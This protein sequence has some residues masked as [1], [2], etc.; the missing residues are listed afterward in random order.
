[1]KTSRLL[2]PALSLA[3][4][5]GLGTAA[6]VA[7]DLDDVALEFTE[8][9]AKAKAKAK[10]LGGK[11]GK[12]DETHTLDIKFAAGALFNA[13]W[14]GDEVEPGVGKING[15]YERKNEFSKKL[16]LTVGADG[17]DELTTVYEEFIAEVLAEEGFVAVLG[18]QLTDQKNKLGMKVKKKKG[19]ASGKVRL[20]LKFSGVGSIPELGII[21]EAF[22][23][24]GT[25]KGVS[26]TIP[27]SD[28]GV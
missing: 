8:I 12:D 18:L 16:T 20:R 4:I 6:K 11:G 10:G 25:L 21:N 27:S 13:T 7:I 15:T 1:M 24:L 2:L 19:E 26:E 28:L 22:T 17:I 5:A 23:V 3:L 9:A 14:D